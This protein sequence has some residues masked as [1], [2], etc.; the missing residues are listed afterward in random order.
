MGLSGCTLA[1]SGTVAP[2]RVVLV[3]QVPFQDPDTCIC[4]DT[5]SLWIARWREEQLLADFLVFQCIL[6]VL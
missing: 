5:E 4:S 3:R 6:I 1:R 2:P